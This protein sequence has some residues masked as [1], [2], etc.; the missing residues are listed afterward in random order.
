MSYY[1]G[2]RTSADGITVL[3][4]L[5][6]T[7]VVEVLD[8]FLSQLCLGRAHIVALVLQ[9]HLTVESVCLWWYFNRR[10]Q[11]HV[12]R[13]IPIRRKCIYTSSHCSS[14]SCSLILSFLLLFLVFNLCCSAS[15]MPSLLILLLNIFIVSLPL[16]RFLLTLIPLLLDNLRLIYLRC[17]LF[18][19]SSFYP[20]LVVFALFL[21]L[22]FCIFVFVFLVIHCGVR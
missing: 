1:S 9:P 18:I 14:Y 6:G 16:L 19:F 10:S 12:T 8:A 7:I 13:L 17:L 11:T 20:F 4:L 2:Q 3:Q 5:D 21:F 22:L 15:Y